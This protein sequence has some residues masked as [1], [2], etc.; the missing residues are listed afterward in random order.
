MCLCVCG[1]KEKVQKDKR[2]EY[3][4]PLFYLEYIRGNFWEMN[5]ILCLC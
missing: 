2:I 5:S 1:I 3:L 4:L